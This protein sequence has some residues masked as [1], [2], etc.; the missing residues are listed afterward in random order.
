LLPSP[1]VTAPQTAVNT[2]D[3]VIAVG[4][5]ID[6][7]HVIAKGDA[8]ETIVGRDHAANTGAAIRPGDGSAIAVPLRTGDYVVAVA[9]DRSAAIAHRIARN[10]T[11]KAIGG[12]DRTAHPLLPSPQVTAPI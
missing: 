7:A 5:G 12:G 10:T 2:N 8:G 1:Q 11:D 9:Q 6:T 3:H 4:Q